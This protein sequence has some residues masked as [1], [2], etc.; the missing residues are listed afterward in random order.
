[1]Y[2]FIYLFIYIYIF[3]LIYTDDGSQNESETSKFQRLVSSMIIVKCL[4]DKCQTLN[5]S[6]HLMVYFV[7]LVLHFII[8]LLFLQISPL[9]DMDSLVEILRYRLILLLLEDANAFK[10]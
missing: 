7:A 9:Q 8:K 6:K 1:M 3:I 4:S 2:I 5:I 10:E